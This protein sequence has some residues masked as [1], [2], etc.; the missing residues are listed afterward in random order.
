MDKNLEQENIK[1]KK[2]NQELHAE[3]DTLLLSLKFVRDSLKLKM[4]YDEQ[5]EK[6]TST[7]N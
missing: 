1:L 7:I 2:E 4:E 6:V 3:I 5:V